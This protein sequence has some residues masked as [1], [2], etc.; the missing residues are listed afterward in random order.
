VRQNAA[1]SLGK[2]GT[3][4]E[5]AVLA[6]ALEQE[7]VSWVR[8][9][10]I[11]ALGKLGGTAAHSVLMGVSPRDDTE[12]GVLRLARERALPRRQRVTWRKGDAWQ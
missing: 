2:I 9:S 10:I 6:R 8:R 4:E 7:E 5:V 11:L 3:S 12:Q 1:V